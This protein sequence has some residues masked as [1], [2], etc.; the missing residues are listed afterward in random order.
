VSECA[1]G[2]LLFFR[3]TGTL[4][5]VAALG[6]LANV[7]AFNYSYDVNVKLLTT[8]L[9]LMSLFL[10]SKDFI[11]LANFF[12]FN[13]AVQP[14]VHP[15]FHFKKKWE[16][17]PFFILK[18]AFI[19]C[20]LFFDLHGDFQRAKQQ[21]AGAAKPPLYGIYEVTTFIRNKDSLKPLTTDT[22]RWS[23]LIVSSPP[24]NASIMLT[25]GSIQ[26]YT[27]M[28][29]TVKK[30]IAMSAKTGSPT[31]YTFAYSLTADSMLV[32]QGKWHNDS[33]K[34]NL[35]QYDINQFPIVNHHFRWIIDHNFY[36][37]R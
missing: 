18:Y 1:I 7:V 22:A 12:V 10:L 23:K 29:D 2:L 26:N 35:R 24:G 5:N 9:M 33:L 19:A 25:N 37:R 30:Q 3:R 8:V 28:V 6:V 14:I 36:K 11:R 21:G 31:P 4:A 16:N 17:K 27:F 13:K 32:L 20:I 15:P 34:I